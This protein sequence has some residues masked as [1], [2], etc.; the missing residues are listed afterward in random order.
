MF[1]KLG[2]V[3]GVFWPETDAGARI[4]TVWRVTSLIPA[5]SGLIEVPESR[6]SRVPLGLLPPTR[7]NSTVDDD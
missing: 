3:K 1:L 7:P 2:A 5:N 4:E 6:A